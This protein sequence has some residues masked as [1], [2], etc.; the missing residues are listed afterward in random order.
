MSDCLKAL[1]VLFFATILSAQQPP[2]P[3]TPTPLS[4]DEKVEI[5][6][7]QTLL[8]QAQTA[9]ARIL[10]QIYESPI[11]QQWLAAR[12]EVMKRGAAVNAKLNDL[13]KAHQAD[14]KIL[15]NKIEW[16]AEEKK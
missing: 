16:A 11:G 2:R 7:L 10:A 12:A 6:R 4:S 8:D 9:E 1:A 15:D 14:G 13:R 3:P 5:L